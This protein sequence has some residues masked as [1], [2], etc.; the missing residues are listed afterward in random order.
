MGEARLV[1]EKYREELRRLPEVVGL[2]TTVVDKEEV[3]VLLL[4]KRPPPGI[5]PLELEGVRVIH[6]VVGEIIPLQRTRRIRP[7]VGGISVGHP[8]VTAGT[9]GAI[10]SIGDK[11]FII[12]NNHVIAAV[13]LAEIGD[14][15]IQPGRADGGRVPD[16]VIGELS[17]FCEIKPEPFENKIDFAYAEADPKLVENLIFQTRPGVREV[18]PKL[19]LAELKPRLAVFKSGRT[20]GITRGEILFTDAEI[21][22]FYPWIGLAR[23]VDVVAVRA[24]DPRF[25]QPGD[26]GSLVLTPDG[27]AVG[28]LFAGSREGLITFV[29]KMKNILEW[30]YREFN[31]RQA[32]YLA[33]LGWLPPVL[34][35][36]V[37]SGGISVGARR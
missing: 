27:K 25:A 13:N 8:M 36:S 30:I 22:V 24:I 29:C 31:F 6:Q 14:P 9:L 21:V 10:V 28:L 20:T 26:S 3:I 32:F 23:V 18:P 4:R 15:I 37:I 7:A 35:L 16:D 34:G 33:E 2:A 1:L 19:Y 5:L 17:G 11:P 12:S